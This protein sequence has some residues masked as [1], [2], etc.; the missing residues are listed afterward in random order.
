MTGLVQSVARSGATGLIDSALQG[1]VIALL[2]WVLIS[3]LRKQSAGLRFSVLMAGLTS[4]ALLPFA[5]SSFRD[6]AAPANTTVFQLSDAWAV[7]L[8]ATWLIAVTIGLIRI[9]TGLWNVRK[10]R[11]NCR[12]MNDVS[13]ELR[14]TVKRFCPSRKVELLVSDAISV[15]S[16]IGF[17]R[18][19]VVLPAWLL[20]DL[21][22][23]ELQHVV[24]HELSH[25]RRLDDW[26]NLFQ[27]IVKTL[28]FFHPAVWWMDN[29]LSLEREMAC[30]DAVL[31]ASES[32]RAYAECLTHLAEK[33]VLRR[34]MA[35]AQ[36]AVSR[37]RQTSH[38]VARILQFD[39]AAYPRMGRFGFSVAAL[40][41]ATSYGVML[42]APVLVSFNDAPPALATNLPA[43]QPDTA[44]LRPVKAAWH[45]PKMTPAVPRRQARPEARVIKAAAQTQSR[46]RMLHA[47]ITSHDAHRVTNTVLIVVEGE[48]GFAVIQFTTW[49]YFPAQQVRGER[50]RT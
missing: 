37:M 14:E 29:R 31:A 47:S 26:T 49:Q 3:L 10:L 11:I 35:L 43:A 40:L 33:S 38:R 32:P 30:D 24:I 21:S 48:T 42:N 13:P 50:K 7:G 15:P 16:A 5:R 4:I 1:L 2:G 22:P 39:R 34:G 41:V 46:T 20:D 12:P 45:E 23:S 25:L 27:Q 44:S 17:L 19:A 9:A 8:F 18:P 36:A 6:F 28:F